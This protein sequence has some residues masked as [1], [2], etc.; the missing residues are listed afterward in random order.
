MG[1]AAKK[2]DEDNTDKVKTERFSRS[3][4]ITLTAEEVAERADR[5]AHVL[6]Q[7]DQKEDDRKAANTAAK[8]Q[9]EELEAELRRISSEV[10]D[11]ATYGPVECERRYDYRLGRVVEVRTDTDETIHE[12]AMT[13]EEK[14]L[15]L[16]IDQSRSGDEDDS[17]ERDE[18]SE[19]E[20]PPES[21]EATAQEPDLPTAKKPKRKVKNR[22]AATN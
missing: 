1:Q 20:S 15:D 16:D 6:G 13:I 3:L 7:R 10:R 9:I 2:T 14:Q 11:K 5:A 8:S 17:D 19:G 12:R 22:R 18:E 4:R 21:G